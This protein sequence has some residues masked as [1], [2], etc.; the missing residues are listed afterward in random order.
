M[1]C[2]ALESAGS[3]RH[4]YPAHA[5]NGSGMGLYIVRSVVQ[6][7]GGQAWAERRGDQN[8]F[9]FTLASVAGMI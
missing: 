3:T 9:C 2:A 1:P 5:G 4:P 6:G 7:W 8:A